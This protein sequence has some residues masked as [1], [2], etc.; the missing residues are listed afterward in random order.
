MIGRVLADD[1]HDAR[2][3]LLRVVQIGKTVAEAG[4]EVEQR[5]RGLPGHAVVTVGR[6]RHH[7]F[8]QSQHAAHAFDLVE[9]RHEM[10]L[11][12]PGIG[13]ADLNAVR[14]QRAYET[15]SAVHR[16]LVSRKNVRIMRPAREVGIAA[17]AR[18]N[19]EP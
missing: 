5:R 2:A 8:E 15:F 19:P 11:G 14:Y 16:I 1:I 18:D 4:S 7:A 17:P 6:T 13:E 12:R 3:R 10:H 9:R